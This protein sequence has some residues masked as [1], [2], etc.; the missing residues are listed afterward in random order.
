MDLPQAAHLEMI[1]VAV[2]AAA[3]SFAHLFS[4]CVGSIFKRKMS[5]IKVDTTSHFSY[6]NLPYGIFSTADNVG[7]LG[8]FFFKMSYIAIR[9]SA[10]YF[11]HV[12]DSK[13]NPGNIGRLISPIHSCV[14]LEELARIQ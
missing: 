2:R 1:T 5:F 12:R 7:G 11:R 13:A 8:I 10:R 4:D 14:L 3:R 9:W 6:N